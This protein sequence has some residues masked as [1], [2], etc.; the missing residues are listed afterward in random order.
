MQGEYILY[1]NKTTGE[2]WA[3]MKKHPS[4]K[5]WVLVPNYFPLDD[6][7]Q[8]M[9][10]DCTYN[11]P[12]GFPK[13]H[14][15]VRTLL[16]NCFIDE[17]YDEISIVSSYLKTVEPNA[18]NGTHI[19]R[20]RFHKVGNSGWQGTEDNVIFKTVAGP[21]PYHISAV[22]VLIADAQYDAW[23]SDPLWCNDDLIR[24][25]NYESGTTSYAPIEL[26]YSEQPT[27]GLQKNPRCFILIKLE[28]NIGSIVEITEVL[29]RK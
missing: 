17:N 2:K 27:I 7:S 21:V 16:N 10:V 12:S 25:T 24:C 11:A 19:S 23:K 18:F 6:S 26:D 15:L 20:L 4:S 29:G 1:Y 3:E 5:G 13:A 9:D 8:A 22:Y 28:T 14:Y